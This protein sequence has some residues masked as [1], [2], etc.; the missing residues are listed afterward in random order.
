[1]FAENLEKLRIAKDKEEFDEKVV[2]SIEAFAPYRNEAIELFIALARYPA[3]EETWETLH[4]FFEKL[5]PYLH[6]PERVSSWQNWDFDNFR[7]IIHELFLYSIVALIRH[8]AFSGVA[9][10]VRQHY[11]VP[12]N[13]RRGGDPMVPFSELQ[14]SLDSLAHRNNRLKV[15]RL[16]LHADLLEQRSESSGLSFQ[17]VM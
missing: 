6:P 15:G 14:D 4:T 13:A 5:I 7:F 16:S 9:H 10:L 8:E 2:S 17:Q 1:M 3:S 12:E 11:Y